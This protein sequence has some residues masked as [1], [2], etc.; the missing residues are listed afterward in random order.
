[1]SILIVTRFREINTVDGN[2]ALKARCGF[3]FSFLVAWQGLS[4]ELQLGLRNRS[5]AVQR[6]NQWPSAGRPGAKHKS[7][8]RAGTESIAFLL[9]AVIVGH[10][11]IGKLQARL[12][13]HLLPSVQWCW[14]HPRP[15]S[16]PFCPCDSS[17]TTGLNDQHS[18]SHEGLVLT[19]AEL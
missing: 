12:S 9:L 14:P 1:M 10:C 15:L 3:C 17:S 16:S 19:H 2:R 18:L 8:P 7:S 6:I 4:T 11:L 5:S 13:R